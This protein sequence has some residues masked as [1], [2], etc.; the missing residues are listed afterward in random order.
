MWTSQPKIVYIWSNFLLCILSRT[1]RSYRISSL[2]KNVKHFHTNGRNAT[3]ASKVKWWWSNPLFFFYFC[4]IFPWHVLNPMDKSYFF[5][6]VLQVYTDML[7]SSKDWL[8]PEHRNGNMLLEPG[9]LFSLTRGNRSSGVTPVA[10]TL[11]FA[12]VSYCPERMQNLY[13]YI[14]VKCRMKNKINL[15]IIEKRFNIVHIYI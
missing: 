13:M 15:Q 12:P 4:W 1:P 14:T 5:M 2:V 10:S 9:R 3:D 8:C 6:D 7:R 11:I